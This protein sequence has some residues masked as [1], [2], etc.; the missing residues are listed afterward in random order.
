M[1]RVRVE[2]TAVPLSLRTA[3]CT[4]LLGTMTRK[5][6]GDMHLWGHNCWHHFM[7]D[8]A[9]CSIVIP[10][11][12]DTTLV[13]TKWLV[14]KDAVEGVDYELDKLTNVWIATTEQD[15]ALV[16]RAQAGVQD[17]SYEPGPYS[18]F[19]ERQLDNFATWYVQRMQAHGY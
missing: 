2:S 9:V 10:L 7:G 5:D 11:T 6:L 17:P 13:R 19:T 18:P 16:T 1:R 14:N 15:A 4:K 12:P 8:H 3:A